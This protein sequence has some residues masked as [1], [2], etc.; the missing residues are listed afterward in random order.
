[1]CQ[2]DHP[3]YVRSGDVYKKE[4]EIIEVKHKRNLSF[5]ETRKIVGSYMGENRYASV[6]WRADTTNQSNKYRTLLEKLIQLE[7]NDWPKFQENLKRL[8]SVEFYQAPA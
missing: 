5:L 6:A 4:K 8:H 2:Q 7:V 1:M 3:V